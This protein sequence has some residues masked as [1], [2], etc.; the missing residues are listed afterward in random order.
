MGTY[1]IFTQV[2][3]LLQQYYS[4]DLETLHASIPTELDL[5]AIK[6]RITRKKKSYSKRFTQKFILESIGF[7]LK[8]NNFDSKIL[9]QI[10]GTAMGTK[11]ASPYACLIIVYEEETKLFTQELPKYFSNEECLLI[12]EF[13]KRHMDDGYIFWPKHLNFNSFSIC[14]NNLYPGIRYTF[15]KAKAIVQ[16]SKSC[17][18]IKFLDVSVILHPDRT[19]ETG[20]YYKDTNAHGYFPYDSAHPHHSRDYFVNNLAKRIIVFVSNEE[21]TEYRSNELKNR[22]KSC[23]Y[24]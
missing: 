19:I 14:L 23:K 18:V 22:L 11:C 13:F 7:T 17:Q 1:K 8:N 9:N 6:Y 10:F 16:N 21:K 4:S 15:E 24:P 5:E 20:I 3:N 12:K 2:L